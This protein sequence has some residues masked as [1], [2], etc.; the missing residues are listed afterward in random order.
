MGIRQAAD[1]PT[2]RDSTEREPQPISPHF[3]CLSMIV[4]GRAWRNSD[5]LG[6]IDCL[7]HA[8]EREGDDEKNAWKVEQAEKLFKAP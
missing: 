7:A 2:P 8:I 1:I 4:S 6:A 5:T 3:V